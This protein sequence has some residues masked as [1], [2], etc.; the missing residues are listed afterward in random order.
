MQSPYIVAPRPPSTCTRPFVHTFGFEVDE[1]TKNDSETT[2]L[3]GHPKYVEQSD[4]TTASL[5]SLDV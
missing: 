4:V 5:D 1:R 3:L 2:R